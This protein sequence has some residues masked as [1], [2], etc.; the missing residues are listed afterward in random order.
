MGTV[1]YKVNVSKVFYSKHAMQGIHSGVIKVQKL[2]ILITICSV[3]RN[4]LG[5][6]TDGNRLSL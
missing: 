6:H 4:Q 2:P 5:D 1:H 3:I